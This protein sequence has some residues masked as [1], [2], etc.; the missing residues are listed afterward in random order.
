VTRLA[1]E[2]FYLAHDHHSGHGRL[3][4]PVVGIGLAAALIGELLLSQH[5]VVFKSELHPMQA[6]APDDKLQADIVMLVAGRPRDRDLGVWLNFLAA[7]AESDVAER[8]AADGLLTPMRR[9][10]MLGSSRT[11]YLPVNITAAAWPGIRL[12]GLLTSGEPMRLEDAALTG[13]V[14]ATGLLKQVLWDGEV[15]RPGY[16]TAD[17]VI[18][19]LPSALGALMTRTEVA[20]GN[21]LLTK[22]V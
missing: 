16:P 19:N 5:L 17:S 13:L 14:N 20:I 18:A 3:A 6:A 1:D 11:E 10:R 12:A 22:R 21:V 8:M 9:R 2:L 7:E 4:A 15:H